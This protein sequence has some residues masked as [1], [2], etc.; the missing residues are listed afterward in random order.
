MDLPHAQQPSTGSS[1]WL[2]A[3]AHPAFAAVWVAS[4][5]ALIGIAMYDTASGW[6]MTTLDVNPL[7]VSL[8]HAAT[9]LPMFLFTLPA[10]AIADI[11]NPRRLIVA[12]SCAIVALISIFAALVSFDLA[13]PVM[14]LLTT[15]LLSAAWALNSPAWLSILPYLVPKADLPGA[16][17]ANGVGYNLSRTVGPALGGFIIVHYGMATPLWAFVVANLGVIASLFWWRGP[18]KQ[19]GS[20]PAERLNGAVRTGIRHA[21]NNRLLRATLVRTL[22][23]YLFAAAYWGLLPLIA[24]R[25]GEGAEHYGMLLSMISAGAIVGSLGQRFFRD[26][27]DLDWTVALGTIGTAAA[28]ALFAWTEDFAFVLAACFLAGAA[29]VVVLTALYVSAQNVLP[30]WVRGRGLAIFLTVIFG[31]MTA[32]SA[33]W[34]QVASKLGLTEALALAAIGVLLAIPL[35]WRWKLQKGEAVDLTPSLH[36]NRPETAEAIADDRGPVLVKIEYRIDPKDRTP[37]LRA[38]DELGEERKRDGA[39]AWGVFED[40]SE[41]GRFEEGYLIQSW[42]ELMHLRERVTNEYRILEDEIREMLIQPPHI[43]F[44]VAPEREPHWRSRREPVGA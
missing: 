23:V 16:I 22:A 25:T 11:V 8:V 36:W 29:W 21:V 43:E 34:G 31:A 27:I 19:T 42:L 10:G 24:R 37:F 40:M 32:G 26:R 17:A 14:L 28:L 33:A 9:N 44:L 18:C 41:F 38:L 20:L 12:V 6:L 13:S 35:T 1:N 3:F 30:E 39:F 4:T 2:G 7:D 15:F 5:T